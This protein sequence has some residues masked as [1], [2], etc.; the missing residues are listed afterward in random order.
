MINAQ[1][2][3]FIWLNVKLLLVTSVSSLFTLEQLKLIFSQIHFINSFPEN[4]SKYDINDNSYFFLLIK[5]FN[6]IKALIHY[7]LYSSL[8]E[9][10]LFCV[11]LIYYNHLKDTKM[12]LTKFLIG[13]FTTLQNNCIQSIFL[14]IFCKQRSVHVQQH[15]Y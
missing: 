8:F 3:G 13:H 14:N 5:H 7:W 10:V 11:L 9:N 4:S 6:G 15:A 1:S 2:L 12:C